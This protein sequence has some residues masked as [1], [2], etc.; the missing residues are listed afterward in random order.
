MATLAE[1]KT[2]L[3]TQHPSG[4]LTKVVD[5]VTKTL[6]NAEYNATIDQWAQSSFDKEVEAEL[7]ANGGASVNYQRYRAAAYPSNGEQ[8]DMQYWDAINGTT[9]WVDA[10]TAVKSKYPKV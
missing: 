4:T 5:G 7:I 2:T 10:I 1:W 3:T 6:G 8:L 9:T